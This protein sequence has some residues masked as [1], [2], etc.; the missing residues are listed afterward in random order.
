MIEKEEWYR[1]SSDQK[2]EEQEELEAGRKRR[3]KERE[4]DEKPPKKRI[5]SVMFV[6]YTKGGEL[7]TYMGYKVAMHKPDT[8]FFIFLKYTMFIL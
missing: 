7:A 4:M 5:I 1:K 6:P 2:E 3:R 8:H